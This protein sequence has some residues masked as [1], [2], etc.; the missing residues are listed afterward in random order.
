MSVFLDR[1]PPVRGRLLADEALAPFTWFRVGGPADAL[2]LPKDEADLAG[3][4]V[5][6]LLQKPFDESRLVAVL[7]EIF[8]DGFQPPEPPLPLS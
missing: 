6:A 8:P 4:G 5:R 3:L 1:L 7:R 2:F